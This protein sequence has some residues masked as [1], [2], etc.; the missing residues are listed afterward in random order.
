MRAPRHDKS[1]SRSP[2]HMTGTSSDRLIKKVGADVTQGEPRVSIAGEAINAGWD[3]CL[4]EKLGASGLKVRANRSW[5]AVTGT[6][7]I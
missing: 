3:A 1:T 5:V 7:P 6:P 4:D 2:S